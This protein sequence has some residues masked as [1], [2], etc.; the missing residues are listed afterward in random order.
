MYHDVFNLNFNTS[1]NKPK[2]DRCDLCEQ[3]A[4]AA[5]NENITMTMKKNYDGHYASKQS[6]EKERAQDRKGNIC[7]DLDNVI[8]LPH[9]NVSN[10]LYKRKLNLYNLTGHLSHG[11]QGYCMLWHE[12]QAGRGSNNIATAVKSVLN[13]V[14]QQKPD[15][16]EHILWIDSCVPQNRNLMMSV[17]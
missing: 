11:R 12:G 3:F 5:R 13:K 8:S 2:K 10:I 15:V 16:T 1:F 6:T 14:V 9:A 7:F 4:V 17:A